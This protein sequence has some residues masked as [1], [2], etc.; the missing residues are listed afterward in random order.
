VVSN[1]SRAVR[2]I[3]IAGATS[4]T[5]EGD[6]PADIYPALAAIAEAARRETEPTGYDGTQWETLVTAGVVDQLCKVITTLSVLNLRAGR[7]DTPQHMLDAIVN[8]VCTHLA[9]ETQHKP[10]SC[11]S[12]RCPHPISYLSR[13][14]ETR[15]RTSRIRLPQRRGSS[16]LRSNV[17]G[18]LCLNV[19]VVEALFPSSVIHCRTCRSGTSLSTACSQPSHM[20]LLESSMP[21][22]AC[23]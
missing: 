15:Y 7:E 8:D 12:H 22:Y 20:F 1:P 16:F 10:C 17:I 23:S 18:V 11:P 19:C 9:L 4:R 13:F 3:G 6:T 5:R 14:W 21:S 2:A